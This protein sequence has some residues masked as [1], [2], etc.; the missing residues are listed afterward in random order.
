VDGFLSLL[1]AYLPQ[2]NGRNGKNRCTLL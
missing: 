2:S 1:C